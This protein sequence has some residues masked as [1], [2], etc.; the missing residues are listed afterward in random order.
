MRETLSRR[1]LL[2]SVATIG[3]AGV[4]GGAGSVA[5]LSDSETFA[6]NRL[7]AGAFD[8]RLAWQES[9]LGRAASDAF[10]AGTLTP[11]EFLD[12]PVTTR[13]QYPDAGVTF[14]TATTEDACASDAFADAPEDLDPTSEGS[15]RSLND[16][17][18][19]TESGRPRPL[20]TLQDA[21]PGDLG[22]TRF[23]LVLCDNP[24]YV[25]ATG[26]LRSLAD[27]DLTE[28]E[29][30]DPDQPPGATGGDGEGQLADE[31]RVRLYQDR[32]GAGVR[33]M[34]AEMDATTSQE[35]GE[36]LFD[37]FRLRSAPTLR[38]FA[39]AL[40]TGAGI[41]LDGDP[42]GGDGDAGTVSPASEDV[43]LYDLGGATATD[44]DCFAA[45]D[46]GGQVGFVYAL[47]VDHANEIQTDSV[48]VDVGFYAEQCRH[49]TGDSGATVG[50][51]VGVRVENV[52]PSEDVAVDPGVAVVH[53]ETLPQVVQ[54][55]I[56][57]QPATVDAL[58]TLVEGGDPA[59]L[60]DYLQGEATALSARTVGF[61]PAEVNPDGAGPP[62]E[63]GGAYEFTVPVS[64]S[65]RPVDLAFALP[66]AGSDRLFLGPGDGLTM[67]TGGSYTEGE[68]GQPVTPWVV[69]V[70]AGT[71]RTAD[72]SDV[73]LDPDDPLVRVTLSP[74]SDA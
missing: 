68:P 57:P 40:S 25:S 36:A 22:L 55:P 7:V 41:P 42:F 39:N 67:Y 52:A 23:R 45:N 33:D 15:L 17:T 9:Y 47:P 21:K 37:A 58:S 48:A 53:E 3:G 29:R 4:L 34:L 74:S 26:G 19:D 51:E 1:R 50:R 18:Y 24:G 64:P 38:A 71:V 12:A 14:E 63:P 5:F 30:K 65:A 2:A 46:A 20:I 59:P 44:R 27:N 62:V 73:G 70:E 60:L 32:T 49:N 6:N 61:D 8:L 72:N 56:F 10:V 69:D 11:G 28:P 31:L 66:V 35:L 13:E 16:D 43:F 54:N